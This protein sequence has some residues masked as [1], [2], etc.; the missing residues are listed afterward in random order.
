V[1]RFEEECGT[2][3]RVISA[4]TPSSGEDD[5]IRHGRSVEEVKEC[6]GQEPPQKI[7]RLS[8][9]MRRSLQKS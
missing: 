2:V 3:I 8:A 5:D 4:H 7:E 9:F 1:N 6:E